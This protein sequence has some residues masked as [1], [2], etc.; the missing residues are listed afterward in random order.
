M[1]IVKL[2]LYYVYYSQ[3]QSKVLQVDKSV[4]IEMLHNCF[5]LHVT[6]N[7]LCDKRT[8]VFIPYL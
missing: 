2:E 3:D 4:T 8:G 1:H 6:N 7:H 5:L